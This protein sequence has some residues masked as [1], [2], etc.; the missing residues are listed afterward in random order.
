MYYFLKNQILVD[1]VGFIVL[2]ILVCINVYSA[3]TLYSGL[4]HT[5]MC[6]Y[7]LSCGAV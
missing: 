1:T 2:I 7:V 5:D 4:Y 6:T 3:V